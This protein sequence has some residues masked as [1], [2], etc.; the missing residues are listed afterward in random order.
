MGEIENARLKS[1]HRRAMSACAMSDPRTHIL[2][3]VRLQRRNCHGAVSNSRQIA[4][5]LKIKR[6]GIYH[7]MSSIKEDYW[8]NRSNS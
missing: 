6:E 5:L 3:R 8:R 2:E 4:N 7:V 1:G